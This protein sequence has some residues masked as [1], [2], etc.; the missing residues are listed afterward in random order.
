[1][2]APKQ[3]D[4]DAVVED[5]IDFVYEALGA[6]PQRWQRN[7][8]RDL[9]DPSITRIAVKSCHGPG[10]TALASWCVLWWLS[11]FDTPKIPCTAP[12]EHQLFDNL[13]PEAHKWL[14]RSDWQLWRFLKWTKTRISAIDPTTGETDPE[15]FAVARVSRVSRSPNSDL[16]EAYGLQGFHADNLLF[17][18]D[19]ASGVPDAVYA[20]IEGALA[21]GNVKLLAIG[22]PN[23]P[24]GW[25]W[26]AF[27]RDQGEWSLHTVSYK[28]SPR[29]SK[30]WAASMIRRYGL[31]HPWVRVRVLGEFPAAAERGLVGLWAWERASIDGHAE[32]LLERV[33][34]RRVL[35]VDVARY[36]SNRSVIAY[37]TG[38]VVHK[39]ESFS[40][41]STLELA[42]EIRRAIKEH[43]P[44]LIVI[45]GDGPGG[46][47]VDVLRHE[48]IPNVLSWHEGAAAMEPDEFLNAR[49]ELAWRFKEAIEDPDG[50]RIA[51]PRH[52]DAE[53]QAVNI[54]YIV[55]PNGKI[56]IESKEDLSKRM[57][58]PDE[59]DAIRYSL[60]PY[61]VGPT[62]ASGAAV[63]IGVSGTSIPD[64]ILLG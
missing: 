2:Q 17:I 50:P 16:G 39:L 51:V 18:V 7:V 53:A 10:K 32:D 28:D 8:L 27:H 19:E 1:M 44:N 6:R 43:E 54:R 9:G 63:P 11:S 3:I 45:D 29:V 48:R 33:G 60:V 15:W 37:A 35:G 25:F 21:T 4:F 64:S 57:D 52:D 46:G 30:K 36:G 55:Q 12:T 58:S 34:G 31:D 24:S 62:T 56:K 14:R 42:G 61:L 13:W 5:P 47:V 49:A 40:K 41:R 22:N 26:R 59:F 38:P 23:V 20:A